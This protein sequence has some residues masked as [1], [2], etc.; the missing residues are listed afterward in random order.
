MASLSSLTSN[1]SQFDFTNPNSAFYNTQ[2]SSSEEATEPKST[3]GITSFISIFG[4]KKNKD[5]CPSSS[6]TSHAGNTINATNSTSKLDLFTSKLFSLKTNTSKAAEYKVNEQVKKSTPSVGSSEEKN[7]SDNT[8]KS[9]NSFNNLNEL[10]VIP[11]SVLIFENR[12][13]H[14]PAKSQQE[15]L[16]HKQEYEKMIQLAK[17]KGNFSP[18]VYYV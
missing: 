14:L 17:K 3:Y 8:I 9:N 11:N 4:N 2:S 1:Y 7:S 10:R 5:Y 6:K 12:P 15:S 13:S 18:I 16:K